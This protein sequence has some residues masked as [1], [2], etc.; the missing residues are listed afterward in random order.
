MSCKPDFYI[1]AGNAGS[2]DVSVN[3]GVSVS[4]GVGAPGSTGATGPQG[5]QGATGPPG[6]TGPQGPPGEPV[7]VAGLIAL[8]D[9]LPTVANFEAD[10]VFSSDEDAIAAGRTGFYVASGTHVSLSK[11]ALVVLF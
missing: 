8:L 11:G 6:A 7:D 9:Q 4:Y 3:G 1:V 5:P 2:C 10:Y